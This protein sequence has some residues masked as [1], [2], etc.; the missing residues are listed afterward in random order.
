MELIRAE[1]ISFAYSG[2]PVLADVSLSVRRGEIISLL[3]PNGSGKTTLIKVMLGIY[4]PRCGAV[5][6]EGESI[7]KIAPREL[8]RKIAYVPQFHRMVFSYRVLDIVLMGRLPH[9]PFF[10]RYSKHDRNAA[11]HALDML[12]ISHLK[13]KRYTE[14]SGGERQ[15]ILIAR[16]LAQG[17]DTLVMDEPANSLDFGNQI[18]LLDEISRL[19]QEGYTFIK[20]THF[21]DHALWIADRVIMLQGGAVIADGKPDDI[22]NDESICDLYNTR[23]S[24]IRI[25]NGVRTCIP[26]SILGK[27]GYTS[28]RGG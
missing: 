9:K 15:L 13:D 23:I 24:I 3:G 2:A 7:L 6:F 4:Q 21:P 10:F 1:N 25:N 28:S 20:S 27:K 14:V 16:A 17:A 18:R 8:A 5:F 11:L 12:S 22:I 19:A 26:C